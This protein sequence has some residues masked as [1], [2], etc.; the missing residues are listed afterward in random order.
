[1]TSSPTPRPRVMLVDDDATLRRL[2]AMMLEEM[3]LDLVCC[4]SVA[5]ALTVLRQ[6]PVDLLITDWM[7]PGA[8]GEVLLQALDAEPELRG[9][10]KVVV[11]SAGLD[12]E[13]QG[14][15]PAYGVWRLLNKP[16]SLQDMEGCVREGLGARWDEL[17][18]VQRHFAGEAA[19]FEA[20]KADCLQQFVVDIAAGEAALLAHDAPA[21]RRLAHTLKSV[22]PMLGRV[23]AGGLAQTLEAAAAA[24]DASGM[25]RHWPPLRAALQVLRQQG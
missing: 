20:F 6:A 17:A 18:A 1:M 2:V 25:Q 8:S 9:T 3:P 5:Q 11:F 14:R 24:A 15:L 4:A 7:M 13:A 10:A 21:M 16:V 22:L 19:L 12:P 23:E